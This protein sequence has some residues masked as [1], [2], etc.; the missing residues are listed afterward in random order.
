MLRLRQMVLGLS[1]WLMVSASQAAVPIVTDSRIKTFVYN[2]NEV[3]SIT[4]EYGYQS[5]IEFGENESIETISVGDR[6]SWQ[7]IPATERLFIRAM[8]ENA[9]TNMTVVTNK[10]A[11][12]FDLR[13]SSAQAVVG[14]EQLVYVVRFYYPG[15]SKGPLPLA[16]VSGFSPGFNPPAAMASSFSAPMGY[17]PQPMP[18]AFPQ[19]T[20]QVGFPVA[21]QASPISYGT[22]PMMPAPL[23]AALPSAG[24][25]A[26]LSSSLSSLPPASLAYAPDSLNY[27]YTYSGPQAIAPVKIYDDGKS[28]FFKFKGAVP[29]AVSVI[30]A[31]GEELSVP[32]RS[33]GPNMVAVDVIAPRFS[34]RQGG[35]QV[36]VYNESGGA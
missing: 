24:Y 17:T 12:Q 20:P 35:Q 33:T 9:H 18:Q 22:P 30:T 26:A 15:E 11:Y 31:S 16:A 19:A 6:V 2:P 5:N 1:L 10:R 28:T 36:V 32:A 27:R 29:Q 21:A 8:E 13:S 7:I 3:F 14:S 34:L 23:P 4:T 25:P